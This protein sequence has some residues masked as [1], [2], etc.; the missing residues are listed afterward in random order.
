MVGGVEVVDG[1]VG[2]GQASVDRWVVGGLDGDGLA[3]GGFGLGS[4]GPVWPSR[5]L[6]ETGDTMG[7]AVVLSVLSCGDRYFS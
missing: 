6:D 2:S 7:D 3:F 1:G 5:R 4:A